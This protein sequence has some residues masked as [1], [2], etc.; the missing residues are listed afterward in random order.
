MAPRFAILVL[1][2]I[3]AATAHALAAD[4]P[5]TEDPTV[6][7]ARDEFVRGTELAKK[8]QWAE[9]L[10]LFEHSA[11]LRPHPTTTY[12]VGVCKRVLGAYT[13]AL[14]LF[15]DAL[16]TTDPAIFPESLAVEARGYVAEIERVLAHVTITIDPPDAGV[17]IDG[18]PLRA[19][20]G[21]P[22]V[23]V[24]GVLAPGPGTAPPAATF[25]VIADPGTHVFTLSRKGY[26]DIVV[27]KTF[28]PG[29][30]DRLNLN[31]A[32]LPATL[33][34]SANVAGTIVTVNGSDVGAAPVDVSRPAGAYHVV[35]KHQGFAVYETRVVVKP[36][37][38]TD[39][40]ATL[41]EEK[42]PLTKRWWFWTGAAAVVAG[43]VALTY[44]LTRNPQP[45]AY[46]SGSA[47]W[48]VT[49]QGR[50]FVS[51]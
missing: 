47:K 14:D 49:P 30:R 3:L 4:P 45:P 13:Q 8:S 50:P 2:G 33:H 16:Q 6:V 23:L 17:A 7:Q 44:A 41:V 19:S 46:D 40:R 1:A 39:L 27:N 12:N 38:E 31:L 21:S 36:G 22:P 43:G 26:T 20:G 35:A 51:W 24:A 15:R 9:A 25:E 28:A 42:I 37:E 5:R 29:A 32:L 34:I 11:K 18:R 10:A 48:L